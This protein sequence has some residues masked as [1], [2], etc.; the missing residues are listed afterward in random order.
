MDQSGVKIFMKIADANAALHVL[1][2]APIQQYDYTV[3][4]T[5]MAE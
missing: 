3:R 1:L 2:V 5:H 4:Q